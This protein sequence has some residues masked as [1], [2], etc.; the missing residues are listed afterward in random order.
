MAQDLRPVGGAKPSGF[1][2]SGTG[3]T[4]A[5]AAVGSGVLLGIWFGTDLAPWVAGVGAAAA[6]VAA[7]VAV[8]RRLEA[9]E[10][11]L[12][13]GVSRKAL[14]EALKAIS[15]ATAKLDWAA[16][17]LPGTKARSDVAAVSDACRAIADDLREDP[18]DVG[19]AADLIDWHLPKTCSIVEDYARLA[20][21]PHPSQE[22]KQELLAIEG[23]LGEL[24]ALFQEHLH[25]LRR[26]DMERLRGSAQAMRT[27]ALSLERPDGR[28]KA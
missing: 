5:S 14:D 4:L 16:S 18:A 9:E 6:V 25:A 21:A 22:E 3:K 10:D 8:P 17:R 1:A 15:E 12:V 24:P 2:L 7:Y 19:S 11:L 13:G 20:R 23:L 27:I 26:N 28:M